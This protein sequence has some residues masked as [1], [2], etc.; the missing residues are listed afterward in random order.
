MSSIQ[1]R[2]FRRFSVRSKPLE[3]LLYGLKKVFH[4]EE[5]LHIEKVRKEFLKAPLYR[6]DQVFYT[7]TILS[8]SSKQKTF[9]AGFLY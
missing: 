8:R 5:A 2:L 7:E 3:G 6:V 1:G 4:T 9:L